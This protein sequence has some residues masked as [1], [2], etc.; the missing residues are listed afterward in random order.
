MS[1]PNLHPRR[2]V[3]T[4]YSLRTALVVTVLLGIAV[5]LALSLYSARR[6]LE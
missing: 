5:P 6:G 2:L 1:I 3:G 4:L